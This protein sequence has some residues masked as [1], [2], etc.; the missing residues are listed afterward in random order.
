MVIKGFVKLFVFS[1][2]KLLIVS[3]ADTTLLPTVQNFATLTVS[4]VTAI[5]SKPAGVGVRCEA[6]HRRQLWFLIETC[7]HVYAK[8]TIGI[9]KSI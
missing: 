7:R 3:V 6:R 4:H 9:N 8:V 5:K 1:V 2:I